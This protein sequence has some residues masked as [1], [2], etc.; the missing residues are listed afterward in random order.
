MRVVSLV[1]SSTETLLALGADV[2]A[3]TRFCEQPGLA[4]IGGTKNPD[5]DAIVGLGPDL[6]VLD[7]E[8]NRL[9]DAAALARAGIDL[10]ISDVRSVASATRVVGDLA[11]ATGSP[12][13]EQ[14][15]PDALPPR[16]LRALVPIWR[17]PWMAIGSS[18]YGAAVLAHLGLGLSV[19][20]GP[21]DYPTFD[22]S[23]IEDDPPDLVIVPSE[24]YEFTDDH[25][26]DLAAAAPRARLVRVD[27]RD[28]FWWGW[29][30]VG[31]ID[32]LA[33]TLFDDV[34]SA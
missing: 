21:G 26:A 6:V 3:C 30:T 1:P 7:R 27:G 18:T 11:R 5:V 15:V 29:R 32:R 31:A 28:L 4:T 8:E 16:H 17:R 24:P 9:A 20:S 10:A 25:L 23:A 19:P 14:L 2:I 22:L 13:V 34:R 12:G 33:S